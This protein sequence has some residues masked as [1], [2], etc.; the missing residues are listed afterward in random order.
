MRGGDW[1][2]VV[3]NSRLGDSARHLGRRTFL[4][5]ALDNCKIPVIETWRGLKNL[6]G[7]PDGAIPGTIVDGEKAAC[8]ISAK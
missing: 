2:G 8:S 4:L 7:S 6:L 1:L 5:G 3:G